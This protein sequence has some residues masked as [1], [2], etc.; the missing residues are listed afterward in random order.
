MLLGTASTLAGV[1]L[2]AT[3]GWLV[4]RASERPV[5]LT[6]LTAVVAVRAFG[7]ARPLLRYAERLHSHDRALARLAASRADL[8]RRLV[9]LTPARLGRRRRSDLLGSLVDDLTDVAEAPV[10][11]R[12]PVATAVLTLVVT[13]ALSAVVAPSVAVVLALLAVVVLGAAHAGLR[14]ERSGRRRHDDARTRLQQVAGLVGGRRADLLAVGAGG[15]AIARVDEAGRALAAAAAAQARG[16]A[17]VAAVVPAAVGLA[18]AATALVVVGSD[19]AAA[20][21]ALLVLLPVALTDALTPLSDAV[22]ARAGAEAAGARLEALL[23]QTPAVSPDPDGRAVL[24]QQAVRPPHLRLTTV[25][26]SWDG[27]PDDAAVPSPRVALG[28]VD[29]DLPPGSR[30]HVTGP[31]GCGKSTLLAVLARHLD[32]LTGSF[33]VDGA[34][35]RD[36]PL[37]AVRRS[38]AVVDDE[39]WVL[40]TSLREN[41]RI[42]RPQPDPVAESGSEELDA[43]LVG[44]LERAG[45]GPWFATLPEGLDTRLGTGGRGVSGGERARL[46]LARAHAS[47][48]PVVLLDEPVAHLDPATAAAVLAD[49]ATATAGRTV[50]VVSHQPLPPGVVDAVVQLAPPAAAPT[51]SAIP[52]AGATR[53]P[54]AGARVG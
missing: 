32:P 26:A 10:R 35:V 39:P 18:T 3:A 45:L 31:N 8:A 13:V 46:A 28:P 36:L 5:I 37:E 30:T 34:D 17:L 9:P 40:A 4:V 29:L 52:A 27:G 24:S 11:D 47:E 43:V 20:V 38:V 12:L 42:A 33:T 53:V 50:V 51:T 21:R 2:T 15:W 25:R 7:L 48:R 6:L 41:L 19:L 23:D 16:R 14:L 22:R 1:A 49:L 54:D 44:A